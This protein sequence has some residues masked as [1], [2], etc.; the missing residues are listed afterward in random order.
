MLCG[1]TAGVGGNCRFVSD[2]RPNCVAASLSLLLRVAVILL[3]TSQTLE[4]KSSML[5]QVPFKK[6]FQ[7]QIKI[8]FQFQRTL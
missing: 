2:S 6:F 3:N 1:D 5:F 7:F 8:S 4:K